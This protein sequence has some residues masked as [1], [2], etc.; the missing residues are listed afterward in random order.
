MREFI[1]NCKGA[2]TVFVTLL[3]IPAI[4]VTGTGVDLA[5]LY[6][7]RSAVRDANQ[8]A[9]NS[10]LASYDALLQDL[11]GLFAVMQSDDDLAAMLDTY[12]RASLFGEEI[13]EAQMGELRM[14]WGNE[15]YDFEVHGF[16]K[17]SNTEVLRRQIEEYAKWRAPVAI[18]PDILDRLKDN[19]ALSTAAAD[20]DAL[21]DKAEIDSQMEEIID[22]YERLYKEI[23]QLDED[24]KILERQVF[25]DVNDYITRISDQIGQLGSVR[26]S[27]QSETDDDKK[28]DH[29]EHYMEILRNIE[30][31]VNGSGTVGSQ[32]HAAHYDDNGDY[33]EGKWRVNASAGS[34]FEGMKADNV[35]L[36]Q[37]FQVR[38]D[39]LISIS[40]EADQAKGQLDTAIRNLETKLNN[41]SGSYT[42][43][44]S[45]GIKEDLAKYKELIEHDYENLV[46]QMKERNIQSINDG[47]VRILNDIHMF[48]RVENNV[49]VEPFVSFA[50]LK[51]LA[52]TNVSVFPIDFNGSSADDLRGRIAGAYRMYSA[53][54]SYI[55]FQ[56]IGGD[57]DT[58]H[59]KAYNTL[60]NLPGS[61]NA[62]QAQEEAGNAQHD[63]MKEK[64]ESIMGTLGTLTS[65]GPHNTGGADQYSPSSANR[66]EGFSTRTGMTF[67]IGFS[68]LDGG[69]RSVLGA[70]RDLLGG[71]DTF[72]SILAQAMNDLTNR[73]LLVTYCNN[74]FTNW[75]TNYPENTNAVSMSGHKFST[76]INYFYR[77]EL[78]YIIAGHTT[79]SKNLQSVS[80]MILNIRLVANLAASYAIREVRDEINIMKSLIALVPVAGK[81]LTW[82]VRP[83]YVLGESVNDLD[84]LRNG[85]A[86]ALVKNKNTWTFWITGAIPSS[87][88]GEGLAL[89]YKDY[90]TIFLLVGDPNTLAERAGNLMMLNVTNNRHGVGPNHTVMEARSRTD[91]FDFARA[92]TSFEVTTTT[93]VRF[94]FFPLNYA[95]GDG[96]I[97]VR[98]PRSFPITQ[99]DYRGY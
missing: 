62:T 2:V 42:E 28:E 26:S 76:S 27:Y 15:G 66:P 71:N 55:S 50:N 86:V 21:R 5:R 31:I 17:L 43:G 19:P 16:E 85:E 56:N 99:T 79:T 44:L 88:G 36:L 7:A 13:T 3:L 37:S 70:V 22:I 74:M 49:A 48:G 90:L 93:R 58:A 33:V 77:S 95:Q 87:S 94:M 92:N 32:W 51:T 11:Y 60:K 41:N 59:R 63:S 34:G 6:T 97:G 4:L 53:P 23:E 35:T 24:Y 82:L 64:F 69:Y 81:V 14:F 83:L 72:E 9:A 96:W 57:G 61:I 98:P 47:A 67:N 45:D 73:A 25:S 12:I 54:G 89:Y 80:F 1:R 68:S 39:T 38:F 30:N 8:L 40:R 52:G 46:T 91:M 20:G 29:Y 78:E 18:V 10:A 75:T 65:I 84:R